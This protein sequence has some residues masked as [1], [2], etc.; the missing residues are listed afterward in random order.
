[1]QMHYFTIPV[2]D[3]EQAST[4]LNQRL[5][6]HPNAIMEQQLISD[7]LDACWVVSV[8]VPGTA[9]S[10][11][12][13]TTRRPRIDYRE[14]LSDKHFSRFAILREYRNE[15]A[16]QRGLKPYAIFTNQQ[17]A[18]IAQLPTLNRGAI[19]SITGVGKT[20]V[21]EYADLFIALLDEHH[22]EV[23]DE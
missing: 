21:E 16:T 15:L 2:H 13:D 11:R 12:R 23:T 18:D 19:A 5:S 6:H 7:G 14:A 20:R 9:A 3:P 8:R 22:I 1:M 4:E 10:M 17:L